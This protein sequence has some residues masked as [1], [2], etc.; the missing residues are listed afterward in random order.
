MFPKIFIKALISVFILVAVYVSLILTMV[1]PNIDKNSIGLEE[2]IGEAQ[3]QKTVE[4]VKSVSKEMQVYTINT[5]ER[6]KQELKKITSLAWQIIEAKEIESRNQPP[7]II[8][9]KQNEAIEL[10]SK[11]NNDTNEYFYISD[12]NSV[13]LSHPNFEGKDFSNTRDQFGNLIV[14]PIV[15]KAIKFGEGFT[16]YW[17]EK[18]DIDPNVYEKLTYGKNFQAWKWVVGTGVYIDDIEKKIAL[19]KSLLIAR[20]KK[21][22]SMTPIGKTGYIYIF[23]SDANMIIHPDSTL[24]GKNF[25]TLLNYESGTYLYDDLVDAY[26]NGDKKLYYLWDKATDRGNYSYEKISWIEHDPYFD[27]YICSSGYLDEFH[28]ESKALK[29]YLLYTASFI[30]FFITLLGLYFLREILAPVIELSENA[31]EV[32]KGN[33]DTRYRGE[34]KDDE[35]GLLATQFNL[36]L[37]TIHNQ[38]DTLDLSVKEKT[39]ELSISLKEKDILLKEIHHRIKNNLFV[40]S[41]IIGLQAFDDKVI[42]KKDLLR[43]IQERI[44]A[45]ALAHDMLCRIDG[46]EDI[47]LN[48]YVKKLVDSLLLAY[49]EDKSM[50]R[51]DYEIEQVKL[52]IDQ[53]LGCGLIINELV[54]NSIKYA[55]QG[56]NN[57]LEIVI[58]DREG[59][60]IL[61]VKDNGIGFDISSIKGIGLDLVKMSVEQLEGSMDIQS[62]K[63]LGTVIRITFPKDII[64]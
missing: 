38:I 50:Y 14:P 47:N 16:S 13:L 26:K 40:I 25:D 7:N 51:C 48:N 53:I 30:T 57:F 44:K 49:V 17:W 55:F 21:V 6:H 62:K 58:K 5:L 4:I 45:I 37:D 11:L 52:S 35:T 1:I 18:N 8:K 9:R 61:L 29:I 20:L 39:K 32:I 12:Y 23:D 56:E 60:V 63:N 36:M 28:S 10:I 41:G 19:K 15:E 42:S 24:E 43:S 27:W 59:E 2:R 54:T 22:L 64:S 34:I 31:K 33:L 46:N 3:L